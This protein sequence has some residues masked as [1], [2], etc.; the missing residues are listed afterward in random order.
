M[1]ASEFCNR[2]VIVIERDASVREAAKLMRQF[3]VGSLVV[4]ET[5]GAEKRPVGVLTDR[6]IVVE[7]VAVDLAPEDVVVGDAMSYE[8][9]TI[10]ETAG[11]FEVVELM[12]ARAVRR[13]P[14]VNARGGLV[15]LVAADDALELLVE[16]LTDLVSVVGRQQR[17]EVRRRA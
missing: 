8:L 7:F 14:V 10:D 6:D 2:E 4:V 17:Q 13:I 9:V 11:L 5:D 12:R 15:G 3:H 1:K 16:E